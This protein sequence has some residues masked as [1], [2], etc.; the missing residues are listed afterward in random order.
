MVNILYHNANINKNCKYS[1]TLYKFC[2]HKKHEIP[3]FS[4]GL[5]FYM[6]IIYVL[7]DYKY[8]LNADE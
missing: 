4:F 3:S 5:L 2:C 7:L 8:M 1:K 6:Y